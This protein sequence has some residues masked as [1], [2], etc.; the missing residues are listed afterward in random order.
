L[1]VSALVGILGY[2]EPVFAQAWLK[3][4]SGQATTLYIDP[5]SVVRIGSIV[6]VTE[7]ADFKT[8]RSDRSGFS[9]RSQIT[10]YEIN[11][12]KHVRRMLSQTTYL[13]AFGMGKEMS[14]LKY[15]G[16]W[17]SAIPSSIGEILDREVCAGN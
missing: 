10:Q 2:A 17:T 14:S 16:A 7:L 12:D 1:C 6:K 4:T 8:D 11:C 15:V 5:A 13:G 3:V 9:Y